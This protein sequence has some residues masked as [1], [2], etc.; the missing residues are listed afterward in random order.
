MMETYALKTRRGAPGPTIV[1]YTTA[2]LEYSRN[3]AVQAYIQQRAHNYS[4]ALAAPL[5]ATV[6]DDEED[7]EDDSEP[8]DSQ[9]DSFLSPNPPPISLAASNTFA[10]DT[11]L[12]SPMNQSPSP[13]AQPLPP[14]SSNN[15]G[16]LTSS[17]GPV[18]Y[19]G[20]M[21][22]EIDNFQYD[23]QGFENASGTFFPLTNE[24]RDTIGL[25]DPAS[26]FSRA[27]GPSVTPAQFDLTT[28]VETAHSRRDAYTSYF[29]DSG[30]MRKL[31]PVL[32]NL[33]KWAR[34][35]CVAMEADNFG[36][37]Q[38]TRQGPGAIPNSSRDAVELLRLLEEHYTVAN[39]RVAPV[40]HC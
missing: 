38:V 14:S 33:V 36:W 34:I 3:P 2:A 16:N 40:E 25:D 29:L 30:R 11:S 18:N 15:F 5:P 20:E 8:E 7:D 10:S 28:L 13:A 9:S 26:I 21:A 1:R 22:M 39:G 4:T 27:S 12:Y 6:E 37:R 31:F 24:V 23:G 17:A 35:A 32:A 19:D